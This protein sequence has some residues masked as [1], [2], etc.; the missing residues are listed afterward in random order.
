M[1][2]QSNMSRLEG[3]RHYGFGVDIMKPIK[4]CSHCEC[5]LLL[6]I[7]VHSA[8]VSCLQKPC[9]KI[10]RNVTVTAKHVVR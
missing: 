9:S 3:L 1:S 10:T 4:V 2:R 7:S 5:Q 8:E 6:S